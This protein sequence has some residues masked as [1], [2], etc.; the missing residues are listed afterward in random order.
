MLVKVR[1]QIQARNR[2]GNYV[3]K[4]RTNAK[5]TLTCHTLIAPWGERKTH[6]ALDP[7]ARKKKIAKS[8]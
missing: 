8:S 7:S 6:R 5:C 1:S 2:T 3:E 4:K